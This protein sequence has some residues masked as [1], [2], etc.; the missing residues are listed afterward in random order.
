MSKT[1][2]AMR[3]PDDHPRLQERDEECMGVHNLIVIAPPRASS[4][5]RNA[6]SLFVDCASLSKVFRGR[7]DGAFRSLSKTS[8]RFRIVDLVARHESIICEVERLEKRHPGTAFCL[9]ESA[10]ASLR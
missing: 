6:H 3:A 10:G 9:T 4:T 5:G 2:T 7:L 1:T 8:L